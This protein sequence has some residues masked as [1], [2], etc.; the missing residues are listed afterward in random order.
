MN[1]RT[2]WMVLVGAVGLKA[3]LP[4]SSQNVTRTAWSD[5]KPR[6]GQ[7]P[8][9]GW[10]AEAYRPNQSRCC[11]RDGDDL[12]GG[13]VACYPEWPPCDPYDYRRIDCENC[14]NTY[15]QKAEAPDGKR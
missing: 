15:R 1:R 3:Q 5:R 12:G 11:P 4:Q 8:V 13:L 7:C 6:N 9:C 14:G 10:Q 2:W